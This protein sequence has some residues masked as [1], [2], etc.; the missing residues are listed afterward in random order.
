MYET[1]ASFEAVDLTMTAL[2]TFGFVLGKN[3]APCQQ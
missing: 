2:C 3:V 1:V